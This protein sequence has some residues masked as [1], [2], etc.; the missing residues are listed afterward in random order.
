MS[1][2]GQLHALVVASTTE[3]FVMVHLMGKDRNLAAPVAEG[4][5]WPTGDSRRAQILSKD[6]I[7]YERVV[8]PVRMNLHDTGKR[9]VTALHD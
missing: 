6:I 2:V 7:G 8:A 9:N 4:G 3:N 1:A 5:P